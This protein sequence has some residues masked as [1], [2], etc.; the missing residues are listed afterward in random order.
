MTIANLKKA[1]NVDS[2]K[3]F[4]EGDVI[5]IVFLITK[6]N[7]YNIWLTYEGRGMSAPSRKSTYLKPQI[8]D[9]V[10]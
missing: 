10:A 2:M 8:V 4:S 5:T 6:R 7:C 3:S 1:G 9:H